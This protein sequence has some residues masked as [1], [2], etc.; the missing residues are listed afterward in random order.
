MEKAGRN[1]KGWMPELRTAE[2]NSVEASGVQWNVSGERICTC[3]IY[4]V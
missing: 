1:G 2:Q 3:D 4:V